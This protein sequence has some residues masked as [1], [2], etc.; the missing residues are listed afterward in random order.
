MYPD[1]HGGLYF[2]I[3]QYPDWIV[4]FGNNKLTYIEDWWTNIPLGVLPNG[5]LIYKL[6]NCLAR[7][8]YLTK[9]VK[10]ISCPG[11]VKDQFAKNVITKE[12][13][14]IANFQ[15]LGIHRS[16][17]AGKTWKNINTGLGY[18]EST[19]IEI[20]KS[21]K[22][23]VSAFNGAFWGS[24]FSST[25]D[26]KTWIQKNPSLDPYFIDIDK[27]G[28]GRLVASGSYGIFTADEEGINWVRSMDRDNATYV[29][30][31]KSGVAYSGTH[32]KGMVLST[33]NGVSWFSPNGVNGIYFTTFGE[34]SSGRIFAAASAYTEGI[35]YSDDKGYNWNYLNPFPYSGVNDFIN[36][37]DTIFAATSGGIYI[38]NDNGMEW[39]R[40]SYKHIKKFELAPNGNLIAINPGEGIIKS[41]DN[42]ISW[43][44]L[45]EELKER[46]IW[47]M[48]FDKDNRIYAATDSGIFRHNLYI[49]P[50]IIKPDYGAEKLGL[51][52]QLQWS[53][54]PSAI[55]YELQ[56]SEDSLLNHITKSILTNEN[57]I[58]VNSLMRDKTYYWRVKTNTDKF[59]YLYSNI[60]KF[61][62]SPPFFVSQNYPNPFNNETIIEFY[63]PYNSRI[64]LRVYNILGELIENLIDAEFPEGRLTYRWD[65]SSLPSGI[66][67]LQIEWD[68]FR[69]IMKTILLK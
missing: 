60:G 23:L 44:T 66:Y 42:G 18:K 43:E 40:I 14:W 24:L 3:F 30:V 37:S 31:S 69:Q 17:D 68:E 16:D 54:V 33:N 59:D 53:V 20:T 22:I 15:Y 36:R 39:R 10:N 1:H 7:F 56:L 51:S 26:G 5:D 50:Y 46:K 61:S 49:Y 8:D 57:S 35:Y 13:I 28:N 32:S 52:V 11:F 45:G 27:L 12:N 67:F 29:Y 48:C 55:N 4:H 19:A 6:E 63:I 38:S 62:T 9:Q 2:R 41:S 21:G 34:S 64:T 25:D 47:D 65:A 58:T